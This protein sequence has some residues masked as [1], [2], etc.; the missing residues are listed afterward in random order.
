MTIRLTILTWLKKHDWSLYT[1][2]LSWIAYCQKRAKGVIV[3]Y[4]MLETKIKKKKGEEE[5]K[6]TKT[7]N[8]RQRGGRVG[9]LFGEGYVQLGVKYIFLFGAGKLSCPDNG[10]LRKKLKYYYER[11]RF[12]RCKRY[13]HAR[14]ECQ[15]SCRPHTSEKRKLT[16]QVRRLRRF[17]CPNRDKWRFI[18]R[19]V[20]VQES[21]PT[22]DRRQ[23]N[24]TS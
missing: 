2:A 23:F 12:I 17:T 14:G 3:I 5:R 1:L 8:E 21:D 20:S 7:E 6:K 9:A 15:Y 13:N 11:L 16:E 22:C 24:F 10:T 18:T 19:L 4:R